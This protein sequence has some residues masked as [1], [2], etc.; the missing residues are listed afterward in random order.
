MADGIDPNE[1][2]VLF[3]TARPTDTSRPVSPKY[4]SIQDTDAKDNPSEANGVPGTIPH[5]PSLLS[6]IGINRPNEHGAEI[7]ESPIQEDFEPRIQFADLPHPPK[8][9]NGQGTSENRRV[10]TVVGPAEPLDGLMAR[11][12]KNRISQATLGDDDDHPRLRRRIS[13]GLGRGPVRRVISGALGRRNSETSTI[14]PVLRQVTL[15]YLTFTG[16]IGRNSVT[17]S[18]LAGKY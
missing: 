9:D 11:G 14:R 2:R 6:T 16:T 3:E 10:L 15:P 17:P 4:A 5:K 13:T 12:V 1:I 8:Q 7:T 18:S